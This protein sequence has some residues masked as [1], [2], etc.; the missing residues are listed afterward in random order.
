[1][2]PGEQMAFRAG[3]ADPLIEATQ[4]AATGVNK[5]RALM[6]DATEA[7]FPAFAAPRQGPL[8]GRRI[9]RE[10]TMFKT[11]QQGL[12]GSQTADNLADEADLSMFDPTV[13]GNLFSLNLTGAARQAVIQTLANLKGQPP[14]VRERLA[15]ILMQTDPR[16]VAEQFRM[17]Q[18]RLQDA[19]RLRL[20]LIQLMTVGGTTAGLSGTASASPSPF[21]IDAQGREYPYPGN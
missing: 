8:L 16:V 1:M 10:D 21:L 12:G 4:G 11:R 2:G 13:L 17:G 14:A 18:N 6:S 3:Y 20:S 5:A 19:E 15:N 7:E 9:A